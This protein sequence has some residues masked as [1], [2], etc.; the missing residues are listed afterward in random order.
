MKMN[1]SSKETHERV[2]FYQ[3]SQEELEKLALE[4]VVNELGLDLQSLLIK[5]EAK[6]ISKDNGIN[7]KNYECRIRIVEILDCKD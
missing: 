7:P 5:P 2:H 3:F 1:I 6:V 4:K